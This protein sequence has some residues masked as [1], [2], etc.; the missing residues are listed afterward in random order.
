MIR[1]KASFQFGPFR[2]DAAERQL[3]RDGTPVPLAPRV[4]DTLVALVKNSGRLLPKDELIR[5]LWRDT[6]VEEGTLAH[7][8][9]DLRR[10]LGTFDDPTTQTFV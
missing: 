3:L 9:S 8:F 10:I 2:L 5:T 6:F 4:F 7:N 1:Q